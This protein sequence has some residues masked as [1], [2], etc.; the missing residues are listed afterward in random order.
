MTI[1]ALLGF[2][3]NLGD[4]V[5][6][7]QQAV[8]RL[9]IHPDI[10]VVDISSLY[11]TRPVDMANTQTD[12]PAWFINAAISVD[13]DL[14]PKELLNTCL[15]LERQFGRERLLPHSR[16]RGYISRTLDV[17][18]LFYDNTVICE[19]ILEIPH[20]RLH[21]RAFILAPLMDIAPD[22]PHPV[23]HQTVREL[24]LQ[25]NN[26]QDVRPLGTFIR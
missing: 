13:T 25:Q 17:D 23:L 5:Q 14:S 2:G 6:Q 12:E 19:P 21:E 18:I 24:Y 11:E 3:S 1:R 8:A 22:W 15:E 7:I 20:P 9:T 4:R 26:L 10:E 16:Q